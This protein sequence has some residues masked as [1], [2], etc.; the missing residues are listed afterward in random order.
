MDAADAACIDEALAA[1]GLQDSTPE[2]HQPRSARTRGVTLAVREGEDLGA[3][4]R[5]LRS[6]IARRVG[7][8]SGVDKHW[9]VGGR[10]VSMTCGADLSLRLAAQLSLSG[11]RA[12]SAD[13][14]AGMELREWLVRYQLVDEGAAP[15]ESGV[16]PSSTASPV[17]ASIRTREN[18]GTRI[19][20]T[21][22]PG[23]RPPG[24][25]AADD[26]E[27]YAQILSYLDEE[28]GEAWP[29]GW[30][31]RGSRS[32]TM[33]RSRTYTRSIE[34]AEAPAGMVDG[35][36]LTGL[37]AIDDTPEPDPVEAVA[38]VRELV[39]V[40]GLALAEAQQRLVAAGVV[41][42]AAPSPRDGALVLTDPEGRDVT[43]ALLD[44]RV[45]RSSVQ[46]AADSR[47]LHERVSAVFTEAFGQALNRWTWSLGHSLA[48]FS[49]CGQKGFERL[50]A[51][52]ADPTAE[53]VRVARAWLITGEPLTAVDV[54]DAWHGRCIGSAISA[55]VA[56]AAAAARPVWQ[57]DERL[58][59]LE[60]GRLRAAA[61][62]QIP[63]WGS[64]LAPG[65]TAAPIPPPELARFA[66]TVAGWEAPTVPDLTCA[67]V[68]LGWASQD[69]DT[70][71]RA[72]GTG[73]VRIRLLRP[74]GGLLTMLVRDDETVRS[75]RVAVAVHTDADTVART[76]SGAE[77][78]L[79]GYR[80]PGRSKGWKFGTFTVKPVI[81]Q[82]EPGYFLSGTAST[83]G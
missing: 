10:A 34:I 60:E 3:A 65:A 21:M 51:E 11:L 39:A 7:K 36:G 35:P 77:N 25:A 27:R 8:A 1:A 63:V 22:T 41:T 76:A 46:V 31:H 44:G 48:T 29:D 30:W 56:P 70:L 58:L 32:V 43:L 67:A 69:S 5:R 24:S 20:F 72:P 33:R 64:T 14:L 47:D 61:R 73:E 50:T 68:D 42:A 19:S 78:A 55:E 13:W 9:D 59:W 45:A 81:A 52:I 83:A 53:A 28:L 26:D 80:D 54:H 66:E 71:S 12:A 37:V 75:W 17:R 62:E 18:G 57:V 38:R 82:H 79:A 40:R 15:D 74:A 6:A 23:V 4:E 16:W 2:D 49:R